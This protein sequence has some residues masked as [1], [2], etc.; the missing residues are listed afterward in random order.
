M[1]GKV[2]KNLMLAVVGFQKQMGLP[3][4]GYPDAKTIFLL[5]R[6]MEGLNNGA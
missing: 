3:V 2:G 6:K 4:T 1:D 5:C